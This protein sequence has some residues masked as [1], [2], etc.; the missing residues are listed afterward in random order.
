MFEHSL[1]ILREIGDI[2]QVAYVIR[3]M[4]LFAFARGQT[5]EAKRHYEE[6]LSL[7][8]ASGERTRH[9]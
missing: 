4:G 3:G 5:L 9:I 8:R 1:A 6:A 7:F 2:W